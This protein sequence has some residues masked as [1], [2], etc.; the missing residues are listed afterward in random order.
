MTR[1][2]N[3]LFDLIARIDRRRNFKNAL[4]AAYARDDHSQLSA[5]QLALPGF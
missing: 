4:A 5:N 1:L 2:L 3:T